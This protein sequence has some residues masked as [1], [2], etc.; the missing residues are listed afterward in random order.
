MLGRRLSMCAYIG[1]GNRG[2]AVLRLL[3]RRALVPPSLLPAAVQDLHDQ[4]RYDDVLRLVQGYYPRDAIDP[5][6]VPYLMACMIHGEQWDTALDLHSR[7]SAT[8]KHTPRFLFE[9]VKLFKHLD[10]PREIVKLCCGT[11]AMIDSPEFRARAVDE[12]VCLYAWDELTALAKEDRLSR[13]A[14]EDIVKGLLTLVR[15]TDESDRLPGIEAMIQHPA[16]HSMYFCLAL[17]YVSAN[18]FEQLKQLIAS[19]LVSHEFM[20]PKVFASSNGEILLS[21]TKHA[22]D[23][24]FQ[25]LEMFLQQGHPIQQSKLDEVVSFIQDTSPFLLNKVYELLIEYGAYPSI[26]VLSS[27]TVLHSYTGSSY[28]KL[29]AS[30]S[31]LRHRKFLFRNAETYRCVLRRLLQHGDTVR[32]MEHLEFCISNG[33][34]LSA[35]FFH[36]VLTLAPRPLL[37]MLLGELKLRCRSFKLSKDLGDECLLMGNGLSANDQ[38]KVLL[39]LLDSYFGG[40]QDVLYPVLARPFLQ[41]VVTHASEHRMKDVLHQ[42]LSL[43]QQRRFSLD[44]DCFYEVR[45]KNV[46]ALRRHGFI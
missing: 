9:A 46:A 31:R 17:A 20:E 35:S 40:S 8:L 10:Q 13:T 36:D 14:R 42:S 38:E 16:S 15:K 39:C 7:F 37:P 6:V 21:L 41:K 2:D 4:G 22:P 24:A 25:L 5:E 11:N 30:Y 3:H 45:A 19:R 33:L 34:I 43:M 18:H 27:T 26:Q 1:P 12:L 23:K 32:A 44:P 29:L 28:V